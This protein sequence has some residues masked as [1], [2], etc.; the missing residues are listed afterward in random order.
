LNHLLTDQFIVEIVGQKEEPKDSE[1]K[2]ELK[3][4]RQHFAGL[5]VLVKFISPIF[6]F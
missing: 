2:L 6:N 1:D 5:F 4:V 3:K